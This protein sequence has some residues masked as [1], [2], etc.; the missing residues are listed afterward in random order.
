[1]AKHK[2]YEILNLIGYALAKFDNDFIKEFGFSTKNAFFEYCVQIGL[3]D[4]TGVIKNRM[5]LFDYFFPNKRKGWWQKGDAYIHRKLWIDSLL[6]KESVKGFSHIVKLFLQEQY[7]VKDLGITPNAYLK[8]RYKSMQETGLEA[9][10][11]F[12]NHYKNIKIFSC[13]HLKDMR[14]FGDGYDFYIQTNKQAFLVEVK[15]I[16]E[17]Q[18]TL[19]LTQ[20]EYEQAQTY[21]HDYVLVV[22]LNLSEKPHLLSIANPLKHLEFKACEKK[23]KSILE[24]H[25][26]GQIK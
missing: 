14:L 8:T 10:L 1:M 9:E 22:V 6:E 19:R 15:G 2:N 26:I 7:G 18:G 17:K 11:Y 24:Y 3:A 5:D 13:G 23:Q 4:T 12:L 20:K 21:S 16:R 25:L